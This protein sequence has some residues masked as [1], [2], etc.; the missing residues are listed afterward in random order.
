MLILEAK[1]PRLRAVLYLQGQTL[2]VCSP[3]TRPRVR[4][5]GCRYVVVFKW[6]RYFRVHEK[7]RPVIQSRGEIHTVICFVKTAAELPLP[8]LPKCPAPAGKPHSSLTQLGRGPGFS[9]GLVLHLLCRW[10]SSW[11]STCHHCEGPIIGMLSHVNTLSS[12]WYSFKMGSMR[13]VGRR[14]NRFL[15]I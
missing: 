15:N 8:S 7:S 9:A 2:G 14:E 5:W 10:L 4:L 13:G 11:W 12:F 3:C 1:S 6:E